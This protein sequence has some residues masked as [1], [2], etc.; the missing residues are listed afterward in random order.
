MSFGTLFVLS[1]RTQNTLHGT[2]DI[3]IDIKG[4][5]T[6]F[7]YEII[8]DA[9]KRIEGIVHK[10]PILTSRKLNQRV[11]NEVY[12]KCENFQKTGS[13]KFRGAYNAIG[14]LIETCKDKNILTYS[15]GN[16][17]Q[18]I[19]FASKIFNLKTTIIMPINAPKSKREAT[20]NYGAEVITYDPNKITRE[21]LAKKLMEFGNYELIQPYDNIDI[22]AGQGTCAKEFIEQCNNLDYLLVPCGGGGLLSGSAISS[23]N[24]L[25]SCKVIGVEPKLAD[26]AFKSFKTGILHQINNP[27]TI[28]DGV[29]T[30]SLGLLNFDIIKKYV[31]EIITVPEEDIAQAM[32]FI[33]TR[34]K[35]LAEPTGSLA[36]AGLFCKEYDL[37]KNKKV[38]VIISGGNVDI[39]SA[40]EIF[41]QFIGDNF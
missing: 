35:I 9:S 30:P 12:L 10:T 7:M 21:L 16:H 34:M 38:G 37:F 6:G 24:L 31:D 27:P 11:G 23:K 20:E 13:F 15:S 39:K 26:D 14:K 4:V 22:I 29:R 5:D 41:S 1:E 33:W 3:K 32:Y 36:L 17:A 25:P 40:C 18:A 28:A 2:N 8:L 19:A